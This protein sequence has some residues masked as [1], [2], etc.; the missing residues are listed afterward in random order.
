MWPYTGMT[1]SVSIRL[2]SPSLFLWLVIEKR[3]SSPPR[4][5]KSEPQ[6]ETSWKVYIG[7]KKKYRLGGGEVRDVMEKKKDS[8]CVGSLPY[9]A[10]SIFLCTAG[11]GR[12]GA[13]LLTSV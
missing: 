8:S 3:M 11:K 2:L 10:H 4:S 13:V 5:G 9:R 7:R 12:P 1:S 6:E